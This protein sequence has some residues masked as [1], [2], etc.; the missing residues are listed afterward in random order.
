MIAG[1]LLLVTSLIRALRKVTQ[2]LYS[3]ERKQENSAR[4]QLGCLQTDERCRKSSAGT[5]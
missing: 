2:G 5:D 4:R 1:I 3:T